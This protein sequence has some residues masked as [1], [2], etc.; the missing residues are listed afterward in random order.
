MGQLLKMRH[1]YGPQHMVPH[2]PAIGSGGVPP[3]SLTILMSVKLLPIKL[4]T[5]RKNLTP[6]GKLLLKESLYTATNLF[7][8]KMLPLKLLTLHL[9][10]SGIWLTLFFIWIR[11]KTSILAGGIRSVT[12]KICFHLEII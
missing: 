2:F 8:H 6:A 5:R 12:Q 10:I 3:L 4:V 1:I 7:P 9:N 11:G